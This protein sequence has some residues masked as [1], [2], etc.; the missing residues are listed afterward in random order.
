MTTITDTHAASGVTPGSNNNANI[1]GN[2]QGRITATRYVSTPTEVAVAHALS[3]LQSAVGNIEATIKSCGE[4]SGKDSRQSESNREYFA[5]QARVYQEA[6][7]VIAHMRQ[8][9]SNTGK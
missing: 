4:L 7:A 3:A 1:T 8:T 2:A 9:I 6:L 5:D